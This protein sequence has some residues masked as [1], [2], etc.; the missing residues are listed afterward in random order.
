MVFLALETIIFILI[1][2]QQTNILFG[3][4]ASS[5]DFLSFYAAGKLVLAG[6]PALAYDQAAHYIAEQ[7]ATAPGVPYVFFYYPPI[8]LLICAAFAT[9]PY[10]L[11]FLAFQFVT[12]ALFA[13]MLRAVLGAAGRAWL[14][15]VIAFPAT[16]WNFGQGQNA[17]LTATLLGVFGLLLDRRPA[18]AGAAL[19]ALCFKPHL[20]LLAPFALA[21][22]GRWRA[23]V[24]AAVSALSLAGLSFL[25]LGQDT[26]AAYLAAMS[27]ADA[28]YASGRIN[29]A[30]FVSLFGGLR[31]MHVP[32][33]ASYAIQ[34]VV[35][36]AC[37]ILVSVVW[38]KQLPP[39]TRQAVLLAAT[40]LAV[41]LV[42]LYD[43][44][45]AVL[46]LAWLLRSAGRDGLDHWEKLIVV[47]AYPLALMAP[48]L[49]LGL[50]APVALAV[51]IALLALCVR[52][53]FRPA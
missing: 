18:A 15:P 48:V 46:A 34:A 21:A 33:A 5:I 35:T 43:Q 14:I 50:R 37:A 4:G 22:A 27:G 29:F 25:L 30:G 51:D 28:T 36:L 20:G 45:I 16:F 52:R 12:F 53:A 3:V 24:A 40:L 42:L 47:A 17:F 11:A 1:V 2:L 38:R 32:I 13:T 23:F 19:G 44:M 26:W 10:G 41:P 39:A 49:A 6:T 9:L 8:F 7:Q 31:L